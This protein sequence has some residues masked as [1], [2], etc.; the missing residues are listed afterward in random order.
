MILQTLFLDL[1]GGYAQVGRKIFSCRWMFDV[2]S[3]SGR[4]SADASVWSGIATMLAALD[5]NAIKDAN[6]NDIEFEAKFAT[7]LSQY[8]RPIHLAFPVSDPPT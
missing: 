2:L 7:G 6:G 1:G 5:F 8:V 3:L 4:Y